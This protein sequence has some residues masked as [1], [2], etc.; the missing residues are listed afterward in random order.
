[1]FRKTV[2]YLLA[3]CAFYVLSIAGVYIA[4]NDNLPN[5]DE[6][7]NFQPKRITK[8]YSADGK[9]LQ[10]FL[11]ENREIL[12]YEEIPQSMKSALISIEDRRFFTHWG[13]DIR[14]I[15]GAILGN[16]KS[17]SP[18]AQGAST[19]TQQLARNLFDKVGRQRSDAS[20]ED[21]MAT[22]G[23]KIREQ[24]TAVNIERLYTKQEILT[25][26][27]NTVFFGYDRYGL[28]SAARYYFDKEV[29]DLSIE[30]SALLAGLL[31]AP[32]WYN[33]LRRPKEALRRRNQVL[34]AMVEAG[35]LP[36]R[37]YSVLK[38]EPILTRQGK[39]A[40]TYGLAPYFIE[41]VRQNLI[42]EY[43]S[44]I[45]RDGLTV[46]TTLDS[47]L[48]QIAEKHFAIEIGKVQ[49][50]VNGYLASQDSS[51]S[52][53]D[54]AKVQAAFVAM[55][56]QTGHVL[57]M[58]GGR[59]FKESEFNRVTQAKRLPGS[60][61]KPFVYTA[62][63]DNN[64]FATDVL[65]DNAITVR[66]RDGKIWDPE[67]YDKTFQGP[68]TLREGFKKSR[69][70]I[71]IKLAQEIRPR[72]IASYARIM[73][74]TTPIQP[75][76]SIAIGTSGVHLL[77]LVAAYAVFPNKGIYVG[78]AAVDRIVDKD[79]NTIFIQ[80]TVRK[81]V[82][83]PAVAVLMTDL[84]TA[85]VDEPGGTGHKIRWGYR[86]KPAA[87]GKTGTTNEYAD[88]WFIGFTPHLV[89]GVWVGMDDQSLSLW[90]RQ[91]GAVAALPLWT[92]FMQDVYETVD[93][94]R[95]RAGE[96][97]DYPEDL[98]DRQAVCGDSHKLATKYCP[99]RTDELFIIEG[100]RPAFCP[101]H[102]GDRSATPRRIQRF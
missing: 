67:N 43:G 21:V 40:A 76:T 66:E 38:K 16:V 45:R 85:V 36:T 13:I 53:P 10:N 70:L 98:V 17:L 33:P 47:R 102:G 28:K 42:K 5:L 20:L 49:D 93:S 68:M 71:A 84:M 15:F 59:D 14:R 94:Y 58:I 69:N 25:M 32:N 37:S 48:Q 39:R 46:H 9:H 41:H 86:F 101:I 52:L 73:G 89:A 27:L 62:A 3:I 96:K 6:L 56:P 2:T 74:I 26:Y 64:R 18:T 88:A 55:D 92:R 100:A 24:I 82:L 50:K 23:R 83:R 57:A 35:K 91:S 30:E 60:A 79:G 8:V 63:L 78:P 31:K 87:A 34:L 97:F 4:Y 72:R 1:M 22:Y 75:V 81:E 54:S 29:V 80:K 95:D 51:S 19:L 12:T 90:N 99:R 7:E 61:F 77:D 44:G 65:D 11:E